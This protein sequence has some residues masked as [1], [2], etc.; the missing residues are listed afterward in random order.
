MIKNENQSR[1][2][3]Q[4]SQVEVIYLHGT[5]LMGPA[6]TPKFGFFVF[7]HTS[8]YCEQIFSLWGIAVHIQEVPGRPYWVTE[9]AWGK[10]DE[11]SNCF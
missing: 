8:I 9:A 10:I 4:F 5:N 11:R 2:N 7:C 1:N 3:I 6:N